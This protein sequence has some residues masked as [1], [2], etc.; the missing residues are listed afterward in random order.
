MQPFEPG[1]YRPA[2]DLLTDRVILVTGAGAGIGR[3]AA[4]AFALHGATVLLLGRTVQKLE[5]AYDE[6][7]AANAPEPA[8]AVLDLAKAQGPDFFGLADKI[9]QDYGRLD[10]LLH[11]AGILGD[12]APIEQYDVGTW[13]QVMHVNLTAP[14]VL[15]QVLL[16]L[17]KTSPDASIVFTS[18]GV[19]RRGRA[20]WGAYA[21]S[22]FGVE[23]LSQVLADETSRTGNLRVNCIDPGR[24]RTAMRLQ[25]YPGEDPDSL[26][27]P[28]AVLGA[29]LYFLG[30]D[31][32][33][34][35]GQSLDAQ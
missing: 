1:A 31:S 26:P 23:G 21:V 15:T 11:N 27:A 34:V 35:T 29:Y 8:I 20:H 5:S 14:F 28:D 16:P 9:R 12:R 30:P 32:R 19:G 7:M 10:G 4:K 6:I 24:T 2:A 33:G 25:A 3:A 17:L 18:S 13:A 22:K